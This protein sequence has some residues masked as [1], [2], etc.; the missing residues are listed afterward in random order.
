MNNAHRICQKVLTLIGPAAEL[1]EAQERPWASATFSGARHIII[2]RIPLADDAASAPA[3]LSSLPD[4]EFALPGE[5]VADCTVTMQ[6]KVRK[7]NGTTMLIC[8]VE[9]LTIMS[10]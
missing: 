2:L 4:H 10:D 8:T 7:D 1:I 3:I 6:D 5:I 9:L